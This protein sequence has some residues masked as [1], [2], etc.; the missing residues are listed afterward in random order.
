METT[1][2]PTGHALPQN[3]KESP[4]ITS[5]TT[6][7]VTTGTSPSFRSKVAHI[8]ARASLSDPFTSMLQREKFSDPYFEVSVQQLA[9]TNLARIDRKCEEGAFLVEAGNFAAVAC[10]EPPEC[11]GAAGSVLV[12]E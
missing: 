4:A 2:P 7:S 8:C 3:P 6:L 9:E 12:P 5:H 1:T 10:W 11:T